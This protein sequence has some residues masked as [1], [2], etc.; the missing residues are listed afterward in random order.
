MEIVIP[1][2]HNKLT[3]QDKQLYF[4]DKKRYSSMTGVVIIGEHRLIATSYIM[5][6]MYLIEFDIEHKT[7]KI[8][9]RLP[10]TSTVT[11]R[12]VNTDLIDYD[13][14]TQM[15][16]V[17]NYKD[18]SVSLYKYYPEQNTIRIQQTFRNHREGPCHGVCFT[19]YRD[20]IAFGTSSIGNKNAG[21]YLYDLK[22]KTITSS[23]QEQTGGAPWLCK[24][25]VFM[26]DGLVATLYCDG[27]PHPTTQYVY[28]SKV[29]IYEYT[30][31]IFVKKK[32]ILIPNSH[33]DCIGYKNNKLYVTVQT[34]N[35]EGKVLSIEIEND[36]VENIMSNLSFPHGL[37]INDTMIAVTQ[38]GNSSIY[39]IK[40]SF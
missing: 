29:V 7:W 8:L 1:I 38:Y 21:M 35:K 19:P 2:N 16:I 18:H 31:D 11:K 36:V 40:I 24:D 12:V 34:Y 39:L 10:T 26:N 23:V 28:D 3:P 20:K 17:S 37:D 6:E 13:P 25:I 32:E 27:S 9:Y 30:N 15:I 5:C 14:Q 4:S 33:V 22:Q